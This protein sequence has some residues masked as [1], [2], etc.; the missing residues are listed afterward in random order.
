MQHIC[1]DITNIQPISVNL[2]SRCEV[3]LKEP[4]VR[5][6]ALSLVVKSYI[7]LVSFHPPEGLRHIRFLISFGTYNLEFLIEVI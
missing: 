5:S 7:S 4:N 3:Q 1:G 6:N 2:Y